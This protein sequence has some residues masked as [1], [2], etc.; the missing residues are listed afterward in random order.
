MRDD[1]LAAN[2]LTPLRS[3]LA[4]AVAE[5]LLQQTSMTPS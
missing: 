2:A 4:A 3:A 5:A 1:R